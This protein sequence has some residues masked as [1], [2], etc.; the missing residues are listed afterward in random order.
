MDERCTRVWV[1][2][3]SLGATEGGGAIVEA[4]DM[5]L[6]LSLPID[7][8]MLVVLVWDPGG[9]YPAAYPAG[10]GDDVYSGAAGLAPTGLRLGITRP[11]MV[12]WASLS[13]RSWEG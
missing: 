11:L 7:D 10:F 2:V 6:V 13:C 4:I 1:S 12:W 5:V 3:L 8:A 9:P